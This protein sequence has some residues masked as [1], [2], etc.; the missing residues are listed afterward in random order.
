MSVST[1][2]C[3][4]LL[5]PEG[6]A[7]DL[8][9]NLYVTEIRGG[10]VSRISPDGERT[11][12]ARTGGGPTGSAFGFDRYL[13]VC[14][15][16]GMKWSP[17]GKSLG[18]ADGSEGGWVERIAP[19]GS[20]EVLYTHFEDEHL[21][22]PNDLV[23]DET[24]NFYFTDSRIGGWRNRPPGHV[25]WASPDGSMIQRVS[26]GY[27]LPNGI[28]I[29][30]DGTTLVIAESVSRKM[31]ACDILGPGRLSE[32]RLYG[33][34]P[35]PS[36]PDGFCFDASGNLICSGVYGQGLVVFDGSGAVVDHIVIEESRPTN[37]AFGGDDFDTLYV[38]DG[39]AG[40]VLALPWREPGL[41]L[42]PDQ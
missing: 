2:Y 6:P 18:I 12:F 17:E 21:E 4:G 16:G 39:E 30:P 10:Q 41:R 22:F 7:F 25:Y 9:G 34:L 14:N 36:I 40:R 29:T 27:D 19:D 28:A 33:E 11:V 15:N 8:D 3:E 23:F 1:V 13:Y 31:W 5:L 20:V 26:T 42:Y 38:T 32:Q 37:V 35:A 24:Q